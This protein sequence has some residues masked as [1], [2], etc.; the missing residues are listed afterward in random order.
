MYCLKRWQSYVVLPGW[1]DSMN[2]AIKKINASIHSIKGFNEGYGVGIRTIVFGEM[3]LILV[4]NEFFD[5]NFTECDKNIIPGGEMKK[6]EIDG[7]I[8]LATKVVKE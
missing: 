7:V 5:N 8:W 6:A 2:E 1:E 3:P 4:S